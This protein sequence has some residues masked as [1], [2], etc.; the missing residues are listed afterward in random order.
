MS[1]LRS[2]SPCGPAP[3]RTAHAG[4]AARLEPL[5]PRLLLDAGP[6][7]VCGLLPGETFA[8]GTVPGAVAVGDV[9]A[10][11]RDDVLAANTEAGSISVLLADADGLGEQTTFDVD[12]SP[13]WVA[14]ADVDGDG[15]LDAVTANSGANNISVLL[16]VGD[17]T[18][19]AQVTFAVGAE[20]QSV[21]LG[22]VNGDGHCDVVTANAGS[23]NV[24]VL[25]GSGGSGILSAQ[26]TFAVGN[27]PWSVAL[28]DL[29]GDTNLDVAA[30][31]Y[32]SDSVSVLLGDGD[33]HFAQQ[34]AYGVGSYP[35][36]VAAGDLNGDGA[37]DLVTANGA[38]DDVSVLLGDGDGTFAAQTTFAAGDWP[39]WAA[40]A[41]LDGDAALDIITANHG[42]D[43][44]SVLCGAGDGSFAAHQAYGA[45]VAPVS[46]ALGDF[47]DDGSPDVV[48]ANSWSGHVSL[49][50]GAGDGRLAAR[51]RLAVGDQ[52][53]S[54]AAGDLNGDGLVDLVSAAAGAD[55]VSILL[56]EAG[57]GFAAEAL[58]AAGSSPYAVALGDLDGDGSADVVAANYGDDS[59]SVLLGAGDGT[60][61]AQ[62]TFAV[63]E[64]PLSVA[65]GDVNGDGTADIVTANYASDD[66]S[67]LLGAGDGTFAPQATYAVGDDASATPSS[68]A[69]ADLDGDG[70]LDI[71]TANGDSDDLSVLLGSGDGTFAGQVSLDAGGQTPTGLAVADLDGDGQPD[72][73]T[74]NADSDDLSVLLGSGDGTFAAAATIPA[75]RTPIDVAVGYVDA[76]DRLDI[77]SANFGSDDVSVLAGQGGGAFQAAGRFAA[78]SHPRAVGLADVDGDGLA[79]VV[80]ADRE[81]DTVS[82]LTNM[83]TA[84]GLTIGE[85]GAK[86]LKY[87]DADGT[88]VTVKLGGGGSAVASLSGERLPVGPALTPTRGG[89][90][91][92]T[93]F[94]LAIDG[95][96]LDGTGAKSALTFKTS[97]GLTAGATVGS[98]LSDSA[99]E[100]DEALRSLTGKGIDLLG[101]FV[102]EGHLGTGKL[103]DLA[104]AHT[105]EINAG[106]LAVADAH[107]V[108]LTFGRVADTQLDT[109]G[110]PIGSLTAVEWI[111][112]DGQPN[113][114][115]TAPWI[116]KLAIKGDRGE[117][118]D[119]D[120]DADLVLD[121][122]GRKDSTLGSIKISG[123]IG[124][125]WDLTAP[126]VGDLG[127]IR[128]AGSTAEW[129]LN[130]PGSVLKS[131]YV[132]GDLSGAITVESIGKL[133][134][135][136][137]IVDATITTTGA[138][139]KKG[140]SI[141]SISAG[142]VEN[143]SLAAASGGI[144]SIK[145]LQWLDGGGSP[146]E[147]DA[148]WLGQLTV[149]GS[150]PREVPG[151]FEADI[152]LSGLGVAPKKY[153][154]SS[155]RVVGDV[156]EAAWT[157][158]G[159][160]GKV[161]I[162]G[163]VNGWA[164]D[165]QNSPGG[166]LPDTALTGSLRSLTLGIVGDAAVAVD[167]ALGA[168]K[169]V[170]WTGGS[171][172][173]DQVKS[174]RM[175]GRKGSASR[176]IDPVSGDFGASLN[177]HNVAET[178]YGLKTTKIAGDLD[179]ALWKIAGDL[180]GIT[181]TGTARDST[182][183]AT[184]SMTGIT[185]G[186]ADG[187][188]FLAGLASLEIA[189]RAADQA[190]DFGDAPDATIRS[191]T[192]RGLKDDPTGR[193]VAESHFTAP[194]LGTVK[195][196]NLSSDGEPSGLHVLGD[197]SSI[198]SVSHR[199][200]LD[201]QGEDKWRWKPGKGGQG[202]P[203]P[204][205]RTLE[206]WLID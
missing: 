23:D 38:S 144:S 17:G 56:A 123:L 121:G 36:S 124:G 11:G 113:D 140:T 98:I 97:G 172:D 202:E 142:L 10:D 42:S 108:T 146:D 105:I 173:A 5:E 94:A 96:V 57:G 88:I 132:S 120:F 25:L 15:A 82:V 197:E 19:A 75:G 51:S 139:G 119:G 114:R 136:G 181:V 53:W 166:D 115:I 66:V 14:L 154:L 185:L 129:V 203:F 52:P 73:V 16:G 100:T 159:K 138:S 49:L 152:S 55:S 90:L 153:T 155:V 60:F 47:N 177:V 118:L 33:G 191:I 103:R 165:V 131:L 65:V 206:L 196:K 34:V 91:D 201:G 187:A 170:C 78:G 143:V 109:H 107:K 24:S 86:S 182:V 30:A 29:D 89:V 31:N 20:P 117:E 161:R 189:K 3:D 102:L 110:L 61:T 74:A 151:D 64:H 106:E 26:A 176:G 116:G 135:R 104:D 157:V 175:T 1:D 41:D 147:I 125:T 85:A 174:L 92:L 141:G 171:L 195:L 194:T 67:I 183:R 69:L 6:T 27:A 79:D 193:F 13:R 205:Y 22:D 158:N 77:V 188:D 122:A 162:D 8:V 198:R 70:Q 37:A 62:A 169:A 111:D 156:G 137:D 178:R 204:D 186:A 190:D 179:G 87:T 164:L 112:A 93:D 21:A 54:V 28:A 2:P 71:I 40:L 12:G 63:G 180:G 168:V 130:A 76:D 43:D 45:G 50:L 133:T 72:L 84:V 4:G 39:V 163:E 184:G 58:C 150:R 199:E 81:A 18:F 167:D 128:I 127:A 192:I 35:Q 149:K 83:L 68:V 99:N 160:V 134:V 95:L 148:T 46:I 9:N 59:V 48:A 200:T 7:G 101:D 126:G 80:S 145:V 44:V 32:G